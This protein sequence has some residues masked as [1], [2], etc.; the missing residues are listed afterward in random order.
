MSNPGAGSDVMTSVSSG[1]SRVGRQITARQLIF[2]Q[3][4]VIGPTAVITVPGMVIRGAGHDAGYA[5]LLAGLIGVGI[6]YGVLTL[7]GA[8]SAPRRVMRVWGRILAVPFLT[9]YGLGLGFGLLGKWV[10]FLTVAKLMLLSNTPFWAIGLLTWLAV[11]VVLWGGIAGIT[12][13]NVLG[14]VF[15]FLVIVLVIAISLPHLEIGNLVPWHPES[16]P[17]VASASLG[18]SAYFSEGVVGAAF[19]GAV[20]PRDPKAVRRAVVWGTVL[21]VA[22]VFL[23]TTM[24]LGAFGPRAGGMFVTPWFELLNEVRIGTAFTRNAVLI[25]SVWTIHVLL[26]VTIWA[27]AVGDAV[28]HITSRVSARAAGVTALALIIATGLAFST[29]IDEAEIVLIFE[30]VALPLVLTVIGA[31][32]L[33]GWVRTRRRSRGENGAA[34]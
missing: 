12:R 21:A 29:T 17:K 9:F 14:V 20:R 2:V 27:Y 11:S 19:A 28:H 5:I 4:T 26:M 6:N 1:R 34:P 18:P 16:L 30:R 10:Q 15:V 3:E 22:L 31:T 13:T 25:L 24:A 7:L 23:A 33:A 32:G 8:D